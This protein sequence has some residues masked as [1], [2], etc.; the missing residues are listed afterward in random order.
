MQCALQCVL[1]RYFE[2]VL[3]F[4]VMRLACCKI[5]SFPLIR[6]G[7]ENMIWGWLVFGY[8]L[9]MGLKSTFRRLISIVK[10]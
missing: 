10:K 8:F 6:F 4:G 2:R 9:T 1:W 7:G 5:L 3:E